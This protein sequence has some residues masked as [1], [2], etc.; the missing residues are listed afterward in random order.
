MGLSTPRAQARPLGP[1]GG[2]ALL[3][4]DVLIRH[5]MIAALLGRLHQMRIG[6]PDV[7]QHDRLALLPGG[8]GHGLPSI[9]HLAGLEHRVAALWFPPQGPV[10]EV[11]GVLPDVTGAV[12]AIPAIGPV[13]P[14]QGRLGLTGSPVARA[15]LVP[16]VG[17]LRG[18]EGEVSI[19]HANV[20]SM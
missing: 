16:L 13:V 11:H 9:H 8:L 20:S 4:I 3:P 1:L 2:P 18:V 5:H 15:A 10:A 19:G 17:L 7:L 12:L 14:P 6:Q